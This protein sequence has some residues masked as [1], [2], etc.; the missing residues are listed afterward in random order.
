[1][2][3]RHICKTC[4]FHVALQVG[5]QKSTHHTPLI[6]HLRAPDQGSMVG[7]IPVFALGPRKTK[8]TCVEMAGCRTFRL[9][10]SSQPSGI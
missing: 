3:C 4:A 10:T 2:D 8:K 9:L 1:L 6:W 5:K 7:T